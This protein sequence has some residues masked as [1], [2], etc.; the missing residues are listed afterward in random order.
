M[1]KQAIEESCAQHDVEE[2]R[3]YVAKDERNVLNNSVEG[4][5]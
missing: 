5:L 2:E 1:L 3:A 4:V